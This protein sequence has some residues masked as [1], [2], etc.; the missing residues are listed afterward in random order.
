LKYHASI[1]KLPQGYPN[2]TIKPLREGILSSGTTGLLP[3]SLKRNI[4]KQWSTQEF[5]PGRG[6]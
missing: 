5:C 3:T 2:S 6:G 4:F 1:N